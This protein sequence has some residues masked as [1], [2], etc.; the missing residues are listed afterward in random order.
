MS[1][2]SGYLR[3]GEITD[4]YKCNRQLYNR[5]HEFTSFRDNL[6]E[7]VGCSENT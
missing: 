1:F 4:N 5:K 2:E 7:S 6:P 3:N